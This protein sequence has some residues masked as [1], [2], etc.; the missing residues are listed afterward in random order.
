MINATLLSI[1]NEILEGSIAD[2]NSTFIAE[3]LSRS[4]IKVIEI[5]AVP[6]DL[7]LLQKI[8]QDVSQYSDLIIT[9]GGLGPTFDDVTAKAVAKAA[10]VELTFNEK[11]FNHIHKLL[12]ARNVTLK[13][14]HKNQAYLPKN[15]YLFE[16]K[17]GTAYGFGVKINNS[18]V[19]SMPGIPYEMKHMFEY[20]VIPYLHENFNLPNKYYLE[21]RFT[22]LPESD[23]DEIV[24]NVNLPKEIDCIINVSSGEIIVRLRSLDENIL[25]KYA[26]KIRSNLEEYFIGYGH[27]TLEIVLFNNLKKHNMS[28]SVAESCTGGLLAEKITSAPGVSSVF[29]GGF[30]TYSNNS[31]IDLL[32]IDPEIIEKFGAVSQECAKIMAA[33][34]AKILNTDTAISITGIAGPDGGTKEKPVGLVYIGVFLNNETYVYKFQFRGDRN[35]IRQ[36]SAK[37]AM[38]ILLKKLRKL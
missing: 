21:L 23:L 19:I 16:N 37:T 29:Y 3:K 35:S 7:Y 1:G 17:K 8:I 27:E 10:N 28:L 20:Y 13:D 2:T 11:A 22:G 34:T 26:D 14:S 24:T 5:R 38:S 6:D 36:R 15:S 32:K 33:N 31:K 18:F 12:L 25:N 4:G 9:T 30:L